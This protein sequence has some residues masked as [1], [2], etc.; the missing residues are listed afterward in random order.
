M[1]LTR[2]PLDGEPHPLCASTLFQRTIS[3]DLHVLGMPPAFILS[4]DQTLQ[5]KYF[6]ELSLTCYSKIDV[7]LSFQRTFFQVAFLSKD[8]LYYN[9][10]LNLSQHF[11]ELFLK[12]FYSFFVFSFSE[13]TIN[14]LPNLISKV[15]HIF[16][17]F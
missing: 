9:K 13:K 2:L 12:T 6:F 5:K 7:L 15:N 1:L 11:F 3:F 14:T 4:Q 8:F 17:F 10:V 16:N